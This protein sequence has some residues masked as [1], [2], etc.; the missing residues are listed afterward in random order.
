MDWMLVTDAEKSDTQ[1]V[2]KL[3]NSN[4]DFWMLGGEEEPNQGSLQK[5]CT[6]LPPNTQSTQKTVYLLYKK[7]NLI[8]LLD[9]VHGFP[10]EDCLYIGLFMVHADW[11]GQGIGKQIITELE[12]RYRQTPYTRLRLGVYD[13]NTGGLAFWKKMGFVVIK[14]VKSDNNPQYNGLVHVME[15]NL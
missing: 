12:S 1:Q 13:R 11:Q 3:F 14:Q 15:K 7:S 8:A 6:S 4:L 9:L 2:L 5:I 10:D